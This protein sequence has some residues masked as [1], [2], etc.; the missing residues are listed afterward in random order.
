LKIDNQEE[1]AV[2]EFYMVADHCGFITLPPEATHSLKKV[3]KKTL[4]FW[5]IFT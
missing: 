4:H 2:F 3:Y 5:E 1:L